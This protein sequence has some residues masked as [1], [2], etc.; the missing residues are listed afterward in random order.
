M[1]GH[2]LLRGFGDVQIDDNRFLPTAYHDGFNGL[3]RA[4]VHFLMGNVRRNVDEVAGSGFF[5]EFE[6]VAPSHAGTALYDIENGFELAVMVRGGAGIGLDNHR[7]RPEFAG[8]GARVCDGGG[9]RHAGCLR[10]VGVK[11]ARAHHANAVGFPVGHPSCSMRS[12]G[13]KNPASRLVLC[14]RRQRAPEA[15]RPVDRR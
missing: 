7:S 8:A 6:V 2:R 9:T 3:I 12:D 14:V 5:G 13:R 1:E 11:F 15:A 4:R 10:C